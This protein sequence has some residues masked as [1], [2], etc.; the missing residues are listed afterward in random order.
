MGSLVHVLIGGFAVI[1]VLCAIAFLVVD[2]FGRVDYIATKAPW[3]GRLLE[4]RAGFN[5]LLL[6]AIFLLIG[7]VYELVL[8]E[9]PEVPAP[10][11]VVIKAPQPPIFPKQSDPQTEIRIDPTALAKA[12]HEI[13]KQQEHSRGQSP[14][15]IRTYALSKSILTFALERGRQQPP[16]KANIAHEDMDKQWEANVQFSR[17][18][19]NQ[20]AL[21][22]GS[23]LSGL[24]QQLKATGIDI[25]DW[26]WMCGTTYA[27][28]TLFTIQNCGSQLGAF[29]EQL[30]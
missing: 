17:E 7:D 5:A 20:Y 25:G 26:E 21:K 6:V 8:K 15:K 13:E 10:P 12:L 18:T 28:S 27:G 1:V 9:V 30:Q 29:A 23:A 11:T 24:F 14:L 22:F 3:L 2:M 16:M 19:Q 4:R